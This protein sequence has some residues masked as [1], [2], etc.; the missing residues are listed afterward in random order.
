[1]L[2][3]QLLFPFFAY[4]SAG[5]LAQYL[6]ASEENTQ[7]W[8]DRFVYY[9]ALP[10]LLF[11]SVRLVPVEGSQLVTFLALTSVAT[12]A[13][14]LAGLALG[15]NFHKQAPPPVF[16]MVGSYS[17]IGYMGPILTVALLGPAAAAP[18]AM[19][20]CADVLVLFSFWALATGNEGAG[21]RSVTLAVK[22]VAFHPFIL[23]V[24]AGL[25]FA[26][27]GLPLTAP[28]ETM[29]DGF[30][31]AA[32][33]CALFSLGLTLSRSASRQ[34]RTFLVLPL[35]MKLLLHPMIVALLFSLTTEFDTTWV[36][37]AILMAALPP[38]ANI[39]VLARASGAGAPFAASAVF[40]GTIV[41]ALTLPIVIGAL[42]SA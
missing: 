40:W 2:G 9:L 16:A 24:L 33:P 14:F 21:L 7:T 27:S 6:F 31:N 22:R 12:A 25:L 32:A 15:R 4:I 10:A 37:S 28:L 19:I 36:A 30:Q 35:S 13:L 18:S 17:N 34:P 26:Q 1:M 23:A 5:F 8:L 11:Q 42:G 20:F 3:L 41:S 39:Y 29:L 38:A